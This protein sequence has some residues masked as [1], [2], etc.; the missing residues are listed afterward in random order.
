MNKG[1]KIKSLPLQER[2]IYPEIVHKKYNKLSEVLRI[3]RDASMNIK[4]QKHNLF[5][6]RNVMN[7]WWI[8]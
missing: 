7:K 4:N 2:I 8:K 6:Y 1:V 5:T 3:L